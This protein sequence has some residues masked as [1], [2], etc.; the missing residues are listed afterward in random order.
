MT[1]FQ[2]A[3][4][5]LP[6]EHFSPYFLAV[7]IAGALAAA[8]EV[9]RLLYRKLNGAEQLP[10]PPQF[11]LLPVHADEEQTLNDGENEGDDQVDVPLMVEG[12]SQVDV[13][14]NLRTFNQ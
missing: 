3:F 2:I 11:P 13:S 8:I 10:L 4:F 6:L 12:E 7:G 1:R 9:V 5:D 14:N